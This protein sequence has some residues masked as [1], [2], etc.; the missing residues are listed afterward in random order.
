M[1]GLIWESLGKGMFCRME[2]ECGL[3]GL[4]IEWGIVWGGK[5]VGF[6]GG[7]VLIGWEREWY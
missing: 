6:L 1:L 2:E 4:K 3:T 7:M 5:E